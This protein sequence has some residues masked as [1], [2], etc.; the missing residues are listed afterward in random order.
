MGN[1]EPNYEELKRPLQAEQSLPTYSY[2][3][4]NYEELKQ[5]H[6]AVN[7]PVLQYLEPNYEELKRVKNFYPSTCG[8]DLEPNYEELKLNYCPGEALREER[9]QSLTM[10]N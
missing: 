5:S 7:R 8:N 4:P 1:L 10:R 9:I 3:E 2:L 6:R